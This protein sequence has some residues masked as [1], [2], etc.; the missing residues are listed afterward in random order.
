MAGPATGIDRPAVDADEDGADEPPRQ[1]VAEFGERF[2]DGEFVA[3]ALLLHPVSAVVLGQLTEEGEGV[4]AEPG[5]AR[6]FDALA[7][8]LAEFGEH[9]GHLH[10]V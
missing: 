5:E 10:R 8:A 4:A 7:D 2:A 6:I 3:I 1:V 9:V